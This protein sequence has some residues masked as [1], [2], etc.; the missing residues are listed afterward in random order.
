MRAGARLRGCPAGRRAPRD[1]SAARSSSPA[2]PCRGAR[3]AGVSPGASGSARLTIALPMLGPSA[4]MSSHATEYRRG[5][6]PPI[7]SSV[8]S[9][10]LVRSTSSATHACATGSARTVACRITPVRPI[11]PSVAKKRSGSLVG[12]QLERVPS[13]GQQRHLLHVPGEGTVAVM[14]LAVDVAGD[15]PGQR[16]VTSARHHRQRHAVV[17]ER[18]HHACERRASLRGHRQTLGVEPIRCVSDFLRG[19]NISFAARCKNCGEEGERVS[20]KCGFVT[21]NAFSN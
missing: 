15:R 14:V 9:S 10:P 8:C 20:L 4:S 13:R 16:H 2:C 6:S 19:H 21:Q 3:Q 17:R 5:S 18:G 11:P 1:A 7:S 12:C